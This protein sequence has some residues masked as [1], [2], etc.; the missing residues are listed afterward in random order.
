LKIL[1]LGDYGT[2]GGRL[3]HL[4]ADDKRL[5]LLIAGRSKSKAF[6]FCRSQVFR[7]QTEALAF[8]R[9]ARY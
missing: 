7:A 8:D 9:D 4:L 1:I 2:F 6:E 5:T 3:T